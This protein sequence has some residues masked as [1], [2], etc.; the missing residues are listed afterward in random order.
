VFL[1]LLAQEQTKQQVEPVEVQEN[2]KDHDEHVN[3][4]QKSWWSNPI[5]HH[6]PQHKWT[7]K[8]STEKERH[9][10]NTTTSHQGS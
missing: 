2:E 10:E 3:V 9:D 8:N 6:M 5:I 4:I 7:P 1:F